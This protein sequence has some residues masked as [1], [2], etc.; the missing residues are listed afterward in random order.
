MKTAEE[1]NKLWKKHE[2]HTKTAMAVVKKI[3]E[4]QNQSKQ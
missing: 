4:I 1:I 2:Y 3:M